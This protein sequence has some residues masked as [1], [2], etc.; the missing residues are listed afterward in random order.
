MIN[1]WRVQ[2]IFGS[3]GTCS[4]SDNSYKHRIE[5]LHGTEECDLEMKLFTD[6][7]N[8]KESASAPSEDMNSK[9][10][11]HQDVGLDFLL[12][13]STTENDLEQCVWEMKSHFVMDNSHEKAGSCCT[14]SDSEGE[15]VTRTRQ[16]HQKLTASESFHHDIQIPEVHTCS[17]LGAASEDR[18]FPVAMSIDVEANIG[19]KKVELPSECDQID[20]ASSWELFRQ[21]AGEVIDVAEIHKI[22]KDLVRACGRDLRSI[23]LIAK[24]LRDMRDIE[25]WEYA[26]D[27]L[28]VDN[29]SCP[30]DSKILLVNVLKL[31]IGLLE[32]DVTRACLKSF[33]LQGK[34]SGVARASLINS[35]ISEG[36]LATHNEGEKVISNLLERK[37]LELSENGEF[38]KCLDL[39]QHA[40]DLIFQPE[41]GCEFLLQGGMGLEEPPEVGEWEMAKV[42][43][44]MHNDLT[45]LPENLRCARLSTLYLQRNPKLRMIPPSF[46]SHMPALEVLNLSRTRIKS[47]PDSLFQLISLKRLFL[48]E[49]ILLRMLSKKVGQ[50]KNLEVLDLEGTKLMGLPKEIEQLINLTC[51]DVSILGGGS[52]VADQM[53][54]LIPSGLLSALSLLEELNIDVGPEAEWW[55]SYVE[56][57]LNELC[58]LGR[59]TTLKFYFPKVELLRQFNAQSLTRFRIVVGKH[60]GRIM[61]RLPPD[62]EFEL[63]RWDRCLKYIHGEGILEDVVKVLKQA[64]A[65][66]LDRHVDLKKFSD[67]GKENLE[68][69]RCCVLG[70]CNELQVLIHVEDFKEE[71]DGIT[72][73]SLEYLYVYYMKNLEAIWRGPVPKGSLSCLKSLT[74]RTCPRVISIFTPELLENLCNLEELVVEDCPGLSSLV[75]CKYSGQSEAPLYMPALRKMS[76]HY[77]P[78]LTSI[79]GGLQIAP[80]VEWLSFYDCPNLK[81]L[82]LSVREV[83]RIRGQRDWWESL[84]W[85]GDRPDNLD[86]LSVT[87]DACT[88]P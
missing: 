81:S 52:K 56:G 62:I 65:I 78:E 54:P 4:P 13:G 87:I 25:I 17:S 74:L 28:S 23:T 29:A 39:D 48:N 88:I 44:L 67:F 55:D 31:S 76:L 69:L 24:A 85:T 72:L 11:Q 71:G 63:E 66:F 1:L 43:C 70:E 18:C 15:M 60:I 45:E 59:L 38:V 84:E 10:L 82:D 14:D 7:H 26:L 27:S 30:D 6:N 73:G 3:L 32:D 53:N 5:P 46:F 49:C 50:L 19:Y 21:N 64:D 35:W 77:L 37:L 47:L 33:T 51:L 20:D 40:V 12:I 68:Q 2:L 22:A 79:S 42:I 16:K 8:K 57:L 86:T 34:N 36:M 41:E 9:V 80:R 75:S 58:S 61:S 83:K